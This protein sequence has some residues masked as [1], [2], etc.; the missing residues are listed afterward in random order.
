M[1]RRLTSLPLWGLSP[2]CP[3][4]IGVGVQ[5]FSSLVLSGLPLIRLMVSG[6]E[7]GAGG[8]SEADAVVVAQV[9]SLISGLTMLGMVT[10]VMVLVLGRGVTRLIIPP[11]AGYSK[12]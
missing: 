4:T 1:W 2:K 10:L 6:H 11:S 7:E 5:G 3:C 8:E 12:R 9:I